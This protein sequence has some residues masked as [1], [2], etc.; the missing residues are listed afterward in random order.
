MTKPT[1]LILY[2]SV[3][4]DIKSA[5]VRC[6][7]KSLSAVNREA[8]SLYFGVGKYVSENTRNGKWGQRAIPAIS[9]LLQK[10]MPGLT[11]FSPSGIK[12]MRTFY[13]EWTKMI[14]RPS[15]M[16][17]L[18]SEV[19]SSFQVDER[20]LLSEIRLPVSDGFD[21]SD[22]VNISFTHH[23]E[24]LAKTES[25]EQRKF[26]IHQ[27]AVH[28]W[29][30]A[31]LKIFLKENQFGQRAVLPNNFVETLPDEKYAAKAVVAFK[32]EYLLD[33]VNMEDVGE[34]EEDWR[35]SVI[36]N[37]IVRNI[38]NFILRFGKDFTFVDS[39][40]R[41]VVEG[42]TMRADLV[43]FNRELNANV[44]IEL[45]RGKFRSNYLG[46]LS[47]YLTVYD[48]QEKKPHENPSIGIILCRDANKRLVEI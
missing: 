7:Y 20:L 4:K 36:E 40:H 42:E 10:E 14:I 47:G 18:P 8:L 46:Q 16:G 3:V 34:N 39:Q 37:Q 41:M 11:G 27:C 29:T 31:K 19:K 25:L 9:E 5:I 22:F 1:D 6:R 12:R 35:E 17:E 33:M 21:W 44:I 43:F 24:I 32:D 48:M 23:S 2:S 38:K 13:E 26:Y 15:S 45:K 30:V 28:S